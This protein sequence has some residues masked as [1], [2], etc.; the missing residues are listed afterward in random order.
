MRICLFS[1]FSGLQSCASECHSQYSCQY[2][3]SVTSK[4]KVKSSVTLATFKMF[5]SHMWLLA[6]ILEW[7]LDSPVVMQS[8][9]EGTKE[10]DP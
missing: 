1:I 4:L 9:I 2:L 10:S 5:R 7:I 8:S 6:P 3:N